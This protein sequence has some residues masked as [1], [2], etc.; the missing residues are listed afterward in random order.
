MKTTYNGIEYKE[1]DK[2]SFTIEY[3]NR[4][5]EFVSELKFGEYEDDEGYT[6]YNHL[7]FYV[8]YKP[9]SNEYT[10]TITLPDVIRI[11]KGKL[12]NG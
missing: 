2:I 10:F 12:L 4:K 9:D 6:T 8:Q 11:N 5:E 7:G 1:G 3:G